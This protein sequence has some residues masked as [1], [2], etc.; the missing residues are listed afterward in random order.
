MLEFG[1]KFMEIHDNIFEKGKISNLLLKFA[2]PS[3]FALLI[4]EFYNMVDTAYVGHYIG[5][6]AIAGLTVAFPIQRLLIAL[7]LLVA[8]GSSTY[9]SRNMGEHNES[10]VKKVI[11][12]SLSLALVLVTVISFIIFIFK[13]PILYALGASIA[14]YPLANQYVSII[15]FGGVFQS[16]SA[17]ICYLMI[18]FG[19]TKALAYTNLIGVTFN[20]ILNYIFVVSMC[21]GIKGSA[22]ATVISQ[23]AAFIF[24]CHHFE[25]IVKDFKIRFSIKCIRESISREILSGI[26]TVGFSTFVIEFSDALVAVVLNN[27][28]YKEGG[29]SAIVMVG[30]ITKI[31]MFMFITIVGISSAIQP[32]IAYNYGAENYSR[33]K[34]VLNASIKIVTVVSLIFWAILMFFSKS[35][36][37]FFLKDAILLETTVKAFRLCISLLPLVGIYYIVIYYY[38][39]IGEA[40]KSFLL[41]IFRET[42]IF[43]PMAILFV[44]LFGITGVW[45]AYPVTDAIVSL[46]SIHL[47]YRHHKTS[48]VCTQ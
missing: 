40:K 19:K 37:A 28:L 44:Q 35:I 32:I 38:Q 7:G 4:S 11:I 31:S 45:A 25:V 17:V 1:V 46:T 23:I 12:T 30:L 14:T 18:S 27:I 43:I 42:V 48:Q 41:S 9:A 13:K 5:P 20:I 24:A 26:L 36:L 10:E 8:V 2:V 15:L 47:L 6:D 39:A 21:F 16:I 34:E 3:V 29:D 33:V 22:L